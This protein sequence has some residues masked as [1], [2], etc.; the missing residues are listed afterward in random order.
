MKRQLEEWKSLFLTF[1]FKHTFAKAIK[2]NFFVII[3]GAYYLFGA[4]GLLIRK[5]VGGN[6]IMNGLGEE[7]VISLKDIRRWIR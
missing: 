6:T 7:V 2:C 5:L 3:Q 1:H 4:V